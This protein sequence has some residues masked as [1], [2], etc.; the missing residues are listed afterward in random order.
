MPSVP[1]GIAGPWRGFR[2]GEEGSIGRHEDRD[3]HDR[4]IRHLTDASARSQG[5][6]IEYLDPRE[7]Q[8]AER[9]SRFLARRYYRDRLI[10]GFRYSAKLVQPQNIA[11]HVPDKPEFDPILNNCL[12]GSLTTSSAVGEIAVSELL[13]LRND[14]WWRELLEYE[15]AFFLQ[16]ATSEAASPGKFPRKGVSAVVR[17][18]EFN[19]PELLARLKSGETPADCAGEPVTL[20]FSRTHH[21]KIYVVHLDS[22]SAMVWQAIDGQST[23]ETIARS[24]GIA[25]DEARRVL[26]MLAE[27]GAVVVPLELN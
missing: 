14:V 15:H 10:R 24:A 9:F 6:I 21:G 11:Y 7:A 20:L 8:R 22:M 27:M 2:P 26:T 16:L 3:L 19:L 4:I 12:L 1:H 18:F 25:A 23:V 5:T 17:T 13:S